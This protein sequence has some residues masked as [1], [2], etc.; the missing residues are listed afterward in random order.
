MLKYNINMIFGE[1]P[2]K[3]SPKEL[4]LSL[5]QCLIKKN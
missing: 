1:Q 2:P 4:C 5:V 3:S